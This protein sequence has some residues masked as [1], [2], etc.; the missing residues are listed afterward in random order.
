MSSAVPIVDRIGPYR[1]VRPLESSGVRT[2]VAREEGPI[3]FR[4]QVVLKIIADPRPEDGELVKDLAREATICSKLNH[5]NIIRTHD[6]FED[7]RRLVL[8]LEHVDGLSLAELLALFR[9]T[10]EKL[11]DAAIFYIGV[12]VLEALAHAHGHLDERGEPATVVHSAV[13]PAAVFL[14]KDGTVKLSGF[15]LAKIVNEEPNAEDGL[16]DASYLA[17]EQKISEKVDVYAA[18]LLLWELLTGRSPAL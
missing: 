9:D 1:V 10:G 4:R 16:R 12:A 6:F 11:S 8:V 2:F 18:G 7:R 17:P 3:G 5:P 14:G 13:S 15:A